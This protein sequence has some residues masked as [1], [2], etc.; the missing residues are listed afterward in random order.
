MSEYSR[1]ASVTRSGSET[2]ASES[3]PLIRKSP[4]H[5]PLDPS[6]LPLDPSELPQ[7][8]S[9]LPPDLV[10]L[11]Q[12][13]RE[14]VPLHDDVTV[15]VLTFRVVLLATLFIVPGA[16]IDTINAFRTT[17]AA[18]L[19][20]FVQIASHAVGLWMAK[21]LPKKR[22]QLAVFG[23][24]LASFHMN[25]GPWSIK[26]TALVTIAAKSG[27]TGNLATNSLALVEI[28]FDHRV[29]AAAALAFMWAIVY[30]GYSY[31]AIAKNVVSYDPK[32]QWPQTLMQTALL[33]SQARG[34]GEA[35]DAYAVHLPPDDE[36]LR[37]D[38]GRGPNSKIHGGLSD[39]PDP[40]FE[41]GLVGSRQMSVFFKYALLLCLWQMLPEFLF[42]MVSSVAV[43][44]YFA[45]HNPTVNFVGLGLGGMGVLNFSFDWANITLQV[46]LYPYWVQVIQFI[47]F[48]MGAWVLIPLAKWTSLFPYKHGLMSNKL[49]TDL[50][51]VYPT[52]KL[53]T[54]QGAFNETAYGVYGPVHLG[55]QRAWNMFFDYAAYVSGLVW[56]VAFAWEKIRHGW[57]DAAKVYDDR[58]NKLHR[59]YKPVPLAWYLAL[60]VVSM[61]ML[62]FTHNMD[63]LF[64]PWWTCLIALMVGSI[65][66]TPLMWLY[67][68]S[69]FQLPVGTFNELLYGYLIQDSSVKHPGGAAFFGSVAGDAWYRAQF[70]LELMKFGFYNHIPPRLVFL[71]QIYGELIGVP[72]NY[73]SFRWVMTSKWDYLV[74]KKSDPLNQWTGQAVQMYHTNAIQY[75]ILGP[76]RL[77]DK[78]P[79]L[80]YG[81]LVGLVC[82]LAVFLVHRRFPH[83]KLNFELWNTTVLFSTL[84]HF[85]GNISTGYVSKFI[86]GTV[87]QFWA[88]RYRHRLWAKYNYVVAAALDTGYNLAMTLIFAMVS[89]GVVA[90]HWFGN[91][92]TSIERCFALH[93]TTA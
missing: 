27:A 67:A 25:P 93:E 53:I 19:I 59:A 26:E 7:D 52:E 44:C 38:L 87:A 77:F 24:K 80:P 15:P 68:L 33:Q 14:T 16:F 83:S 86:G 9:E 91:N 46:M 37:G 3:S 70:H 88:F 29:P 76:R 60:F 8:P 42:P 41:R 85:Y 1:S 66:I 18:Y 92:E 54:A 61:A 13:V 75:V 12:A 34:S 39:S 57:R 74:G 73:L 81:F 82:P 5:V 71:A 32:F 49:F 51:A 4:L 55:P 22:I 20:F 11:S 69:N 36:E 40:D 31:A 79:V 10:D 6:N 78:Y 30:A 2:S 17:S 45:P 64:M 65:I 35:Q 28:F 84:S 62:V 90:P 63:S 56:V 43:L 72:V 89:M 23:R 50:G 21:T 47:G 48:V 58:L